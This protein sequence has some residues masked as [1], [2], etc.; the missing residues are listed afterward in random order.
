MDQGDLGS[1]LMF[2][3]DF[4]DEVPALEILQ[5]Q[6]HPC[7]QNPP[8]MDFSH[9]KPGF[10]SGSNPPMS[11][12]NQ[13]IATSAHTN[14]TEILD[15]SVENAST[16]IPVPVNPDPLKETTQASNPT[17]VHFAYHH[18]SAT[19]INY[20]YII[21][22][23][24]TLLSITYDDMLVYVYQENSELQPPAKDQNK[25]LPASDQ[26]NSDRN[27]SPP[28]HEHISQDS[29]TNHPVISTAPNLSPM[30]PS[31]FN[32]PLSG[33]PPQQQLP[34]VS[35]LE[36]V[37]L[38]SSIG[39]S[40][41]LLN[42]VNTSHSLMG[43]TYSG[44]GGS[45]PALGN[46]TN[47]QQTKSTFLLPPLSGTKSLQYS[48]LTDEMIPQMAIVPP[49]NS[50]HE[51]SL[52]H[53]NQLITRTENGLPNEL[54][55]KKG[56]TPLNLSSTLSAD[57]L[58]Q[59]QRPLPNYYPTSFPQS[60]T[61]KGTVNQQLPPWLCT[62]NAPFMP[63][64]TPSRSQTNQFQAPNA[65]DSQ[66]TNAMLP[67]SSVPIRPQNSANQLQ[68]FIPVPENAFNTQ[69]QSSMIPGYSPLM[70][71]QNL[72]YQSN[73]VPMAANPQD[74]QRC[75]N[76][77]PVPSM[78]LGLRP[79]E[80]LHHQ[81]LNQ[82]ALT[83]DASNFQ[84]FN[85][86]HP[87]PNASLLPTIPESNGRNQSMM[88]QSLMLPGAQNSE[89]PGPFNQPARPSMAYHMPGSSQ[90][91]Q[92]LNPSTQR[93]IN[94]YNPA[95]A[96]YPQLELS[97]GSRDEQPSVGPGRRRRGRPS[98][99]FE[100]GESSSSTS[101]KR[102]R[103]SNFP[104]GGSNLQERG[105]A[106]QSQVNQPYLSNPFSSSRPIKNSV[107]DPIFEGIGLPVDPHLRLFN[108]NANL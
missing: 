17:A 102:P 61:G 97:L 24:I 54:L 43:S 50:E 63:L 42:C 101:N 32:T 11:M 1:S 68:Q 72:P 23:K 53:P 49:F 65:F 60:S 3:F 25:E 18:F 82:A 39:S 26:V 47:M 36:N 73:Q 108:A 76:I 46:A 30:P 40:Q 7:Q 94:G 64:L 95:G 22:R 34:Y 10:P 84:R 104:Y 6:S 16:L 62:Q 13:N 52:K 56:M 4:D 88:P 93:K 37:E 78:A 20:V 41:S 33:A 98:I 44:Y 70:R 12:S 85:Y 87:Q 5:S 74:P 45:D 75:N 35:T 79:P 90:L 59:N 89:L 81:Q 29:T 77:M 48:P 99:R 19:H 15:P 105:S 106:S 86:F 67:G 55:H 83:P 96:T 66:C 2:D 9:E 71:P 28:G 38:G 14:T 100:L 51:T 27:L 69:S 58:A 91:N 31:S 8:V 57:Q 107:Y 103:T 80:Y 21:H 92:I